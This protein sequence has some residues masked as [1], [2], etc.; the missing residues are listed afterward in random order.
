[1]NILIALPG[2]AIWLLSGYRRKDIE[3]E[4]RESSSN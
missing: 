2:G 3:A 1:M 4:L